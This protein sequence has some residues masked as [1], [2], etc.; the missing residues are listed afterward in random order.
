[1]IAGKSAY[2]PLE[3]E[4]ISTKPKADSSIREGD[5]V[6]F[7]SGSPAMTV[8]RATEDQLWILDTAYPRICLTKCDQGKMDERGWYSSLPC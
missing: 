7:N 6:F 1:M 4:R 5:A 8:S 2:E 3:L